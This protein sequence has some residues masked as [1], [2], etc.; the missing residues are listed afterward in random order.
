MSKQLVETK[1]QQVSGF[2][3]NPAN[4]TEAMEFAKIMSDSDIVPKEYKGKP[5][6]ILVAIQMGNE[7]GLQPMQALQSIS[8][9]NGKA[10]IWGDAALALC[11]NHD[12]FEW[13]DE[14]IIQD[15]QGNH[16][17]YCIVKRKGHEPYGADK[18]YSVEDAKKAGLWGKDIWQKY[19]KRM[20]QMRARGFSLRDKFPDALKGLYIRE[21]VMDYEEIH[22]SNGTTL[23]Q[24][25]LKNTKGSR[26]DILADIINP[27]N[28]KPDITLTDAEFEEDTIWKEAKDDESY[29]DLLENLEASND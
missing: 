5:G 17:A 15:A 21:E 4:L 29:D 24:E 3:M 10:T 28:P 25:K 16:K 18:P 12:S 23:A 13:H 14:K 1:K 20:L 27:V 19:P 8:V 9:I 26:A 22:Q 7:V 11:M 6:N 2:M